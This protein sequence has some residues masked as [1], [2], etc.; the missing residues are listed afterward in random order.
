MKITKH[1]ILA[2]AAF[3]SREPTR[4][5]MNNLHVR[6]GVVEATDG[7]M[8]IR[9]KAH[10]V[11][12]EGEGFLPRSIEV[13]A[14]VTAKTKKA[15]GE[16]PASQRVVVQDGQASYRDRQGDPAVAT[17]AKPTEGIY[18]PTDDVW[19]AEAEREDDNAA[20]V[21]VR[22]LESLVAALKAVH[23]ESVLIRVAGER[24]ALRFTAK[25]RDPVTDSRHRVG[26]LIMPQVGENPP[27]GLL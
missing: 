20:W 16:D 14:R 24:E 8:L 27:E 21:G 3:A 7:T 11:E 15:T 5:S 9:V 18:P 4:Y 26:G 19:P 12:T 23:A 1:Q 2:A 22:Q 10:D 6:D 13:V 17:V 25:G